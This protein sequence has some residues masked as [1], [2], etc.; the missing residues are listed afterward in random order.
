[1]Q[2]LDAFIARLEQ[3]LLAV[4]LSMMIVVGFLQ[5]VLRNFF[6]TGISW[7]DPVL[8]NLVVWIGFI[9]AALATREGK[10]IQI[11]LLAGWLKGR[12]AA[13]AH[14]VSNLFS[15]VVCLVLAWAGVK[16]VQ[17]EMIMGEEALLFFPMW[18]LQLII[19]VTFLLMALRFGLRAVQGKPAASAPQGASHPKGEP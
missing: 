17:V 10:H 15:M 9:G 14:I 7:G 18:S 12:G 8:R 16:F 11:D 1:M 4:L 19:P 2:R 5:I 3:Y 13:L 6:A